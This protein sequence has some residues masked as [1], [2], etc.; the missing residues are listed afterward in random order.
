[1]IGKIQFL[2]F[3]GTTIFFTDLLHVLTIYFMG[4]CVKHY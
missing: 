4:I 3:S 2:M 1:M